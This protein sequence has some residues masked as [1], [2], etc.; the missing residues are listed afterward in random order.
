M[1]RTTIRTTTISAALLLAAVAGAAAAAETV[2]PFAGSE[3]VGQYEADFVR[4]HYLE[5]L[6]P[7]AEPAT[8]EGRL[9]SRLL[10]KPEAKSN[11]EVFKSFE[12][13]LRGA[14]FEMLT[15]ADDK[16]V[17]ELR[18]RAVN[19]KA[20]N[21]VLGR[22][23]RLGDRRTGVGEVALAST[24]A[25]EYLAARKRLGG[26]D[27]LVVVSPSRSGIYTIEQVESAAMEADTVTLTLDDLRA[28]IASEGRIALYG[29][30]FD[31][32][33]ARIRETS[34]ATLATIVE[35]LRENPRRS[36]YVVGHTDDEGSLGGNLEL[37]R[38]RA[39]STV[40]ALVA[41]LPDAGGRLQ[42]HGVGPL[43]PVATNQQPDGRQLNRRVELV[44]ALD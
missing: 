8:V 2:S 34:R 22:A 12:R 1:T 39:K 27:V 37:S 28:Q 40:A 30:H 36:F 5:S 4:F 33:S 32:G 20:W 42:P 44:S 38:A 18:V 31:S 10:R 23:Y 6:D 13:E 26:A 29:I 7:A 16:R 9:S 43:A 14:G 11:L 3:P 19:D 25:Q 17:V 15:V 24:Q 21:D 41:Q 35:Y